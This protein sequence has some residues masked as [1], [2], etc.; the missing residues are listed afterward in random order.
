MAPTSVIWQLFH[1]DNKQYLTD[2]SHKNAFCKG[3]VKHWTD[4]LSSSDSSAVATGE[5]DA[6]RSNDEL[7]RA[8]Q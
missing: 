8:G 4:R 7:K 3:C 5:L 1:S 2:K 6:V